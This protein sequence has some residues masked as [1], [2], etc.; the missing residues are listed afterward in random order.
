MKIEILDYRPNDNQTL[1]ARIDVK[2]VYSDSKSETFRGLNL[3]TKEARKWLSVP[4]IKVDEKWIPMYERTPPLRETIF[5]EIMKALET[6]DK[7][8]V[9]DDTNLW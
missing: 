1:I 6:Y 7:P 9:T 3:F 5:P 2:V 4:N 8:S